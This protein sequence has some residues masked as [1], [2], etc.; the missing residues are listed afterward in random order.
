MQTATAPVMRERA[1]LQPGQAIRLAGVPFE[2]KGFRS[3]GPRLV[4]A[5]Y[6]QVDR[7]VFY[8]G[9]IVDGSDGLAYRVLDADGGWAITVIR[10]SI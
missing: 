3:G 6:Q 7:G 8:P 4:H 5:D 10:V 2:V 1:T 9:A